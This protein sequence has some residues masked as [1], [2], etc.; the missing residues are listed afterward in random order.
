MGNFFLAKARPPYS[1]SLEFS[2]EDLATL[3]MFASQAPLVVSNAR[4][5]RDEQQARNDLET[6]VNTSPVVVAVFDARSGLRVYFNQEARRIVDVLREPGQSPEQ[7]LDRLTVR[8]GGRK[9][10]SRQESP[11]VQ[12]FGIGD[13]IR[14]QEIVM[15]VRSGGSVSELVNA[16]L[17]RSESGEMGSF[18][19]TM[20]KLTNLEE[21]EWLRAEFLAMVSYELR[22]PPPRPRVPSPPCWTP[23]PPWT[24]PKWSSSTGSST[25]RRTG[26]GPCLATC[27]AWPASRWARCPSPRSPLMSPCW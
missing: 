14:A 26:C 24:P 23:S 2:P 27:W 15:S 22:E 4:R 13:T 5:F 6:L 11:L 3:V 20:Q 19:V 25:L 7:L 12:L 17:I 9:K 16:T 1:E 10:F 21:L 18:V 8:W